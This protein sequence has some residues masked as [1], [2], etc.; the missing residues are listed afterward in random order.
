MPGNSLPLA[1]QTGL[2]KK[3]QI[4]DLWWGNTYIVFITASVPLVQAL[5]YFIIFFLPFSFSNA[6]CNTVVQ[7]IML[8]CKHWKRSFILFRFTALVRRLE[9]KSGN[10]SSFWFVVLSWRFQRPLGIHKI[11]WSRLL[12]HLFRLA[13]VYL[14]SVVWRAQCTLGCIKF[15]SSPTSQKQCSHRIP[16][17]TVKI[18]RFLFFHVLCFTCPFKKNPKWLFG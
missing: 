13:Y 18:K 6:S 15:I 14:S 9:L 16:H 10:I 12:V 3:Y 5:C 2:D 17:V 1:C 7:N 8:I 4:C 11:Y